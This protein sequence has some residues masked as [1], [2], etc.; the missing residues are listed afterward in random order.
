MKKSCL[1]IYGK[2]TDRRVADAICV[3]FVYRKFSL[4]SINPH[5]SFVLFFCVSFSFCVVHTYGI[6]TSSDTHLASAV[7][8]HKKMLALK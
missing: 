8:L 1:A 3:H 5:R 4:D 7:E 2:Y 6:P